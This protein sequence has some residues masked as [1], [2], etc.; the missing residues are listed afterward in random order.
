[1]PFDDHIVVESQDFID[2]VIVLV[3][4][5]DDD[6]VDSLVDALDDKPKVGNALQC[7]G[8]VAPERGLCLLYTSR[9]V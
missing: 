5:H 8:P 1:V 9:C 3:A 7:H 4:V 2:Q 6:G